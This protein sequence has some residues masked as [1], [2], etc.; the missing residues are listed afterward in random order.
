M[1]V[2]GSKPPNGAANPEILKEWRTKIKTLQV[3]RQ[4]SYDDD[5]DTH[6]FVGVAG[7]W[8]RIWEEKAQGE[9][10]TLLSNRCQALT[11]LSGSFQDQD[12]D[13]QVKEMSDRCVEKLGESGL[14]SIVCLSALALSHILSFGRKALAFKAPIDG[15]ELGLESLLECARYLKSLH[16]AA[17]NGVSTMQKSAE[18][19]MEALPSK[20]EEITVEAQ[21]A[22][23]ICIGRAEQ[24]LQKAMEAALDALFAKIAMEVSARGRK[25]VA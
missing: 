12:Q 24:D 7:S 5:D 19:C 1:R 25:H 23:Y 10:G 9:F 20:G 3:R 11:K 8:P 14:I 21:T 2:R 13:R 6:S 4:S 18:A 16:E 15:S 22:L 17:L